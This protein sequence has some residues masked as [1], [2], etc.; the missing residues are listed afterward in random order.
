M[1]VNLWGPSFWTVLHGLAKLYD[2]DF[3]KN[4]ESLQNPLDLVQNLSKLLSCPVCRDHFHEIYSSMEK[5]VKGAFSFWMY[6]AHSKVLETQWRDAVQKFQ[7][8]THIANDIKDLLLRET[9]YKKPSFQTVERK[10]TFHYT[11]LIPTRDFA[12]VLVCL[13][14]IHD[15]P[16]IQT[17]VKPWLSAIQR[18]GFQ[19]I[20]SDV[21]SS[22]DPY[23]TA[24]VYKYG[25]DTPELRKIVDD[26]LIG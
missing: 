4:Q 15:A 7:D 14:R 8:K 25:S 22:E 6:R 3:R 16:T 23:S 9:L 5:P 17:Y 11:D 21:L 2:E 12:T 10:L 26:V 1:N 19:N 20:L 24:L 13:F 18:F